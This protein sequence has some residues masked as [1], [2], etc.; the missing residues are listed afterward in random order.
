MTLNDRLCSVALAITV[1]LLF[2][3]AAEAGAPPGYAFVPA[4]YGA[5]N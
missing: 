4:N 3:V 5:L 2:S 1:T